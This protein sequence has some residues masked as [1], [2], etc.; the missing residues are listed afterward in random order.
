M[1]FFPSYAKAMKMSTNNNE[2]VMIKNQEDKHCFLVGPIDELARA[3]VIKRYSAFKIYSSDS[4]EVMLIM[5]IECYPPQT[6]YR[7]AKELGLVEVLRDSNRFSD[8]DLDAYKAKEVFIK[9]VKDIATS[10]IIFLRLFTNLTITTDDF[11][12]DESCS[13]DNGG[14]LRY[15]FNGPPFRREVR[16]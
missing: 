8:A 16:Y 12:I 9:G 6:V 3:I 13:E 2:I 1:R 11:W 10:L 4:K 15:Y 14:K 7:T 5:D